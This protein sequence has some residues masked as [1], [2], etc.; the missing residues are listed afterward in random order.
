MMKKL[1]VLSLALIAIGCAKTETTTEETSQTPTTETTT[2]TTT[3]PPAPAATNQSS[4]LLVSKENITLTSNMKQ[5]SSVVELS[6]GCKFDLVVEGFT[7]DTN[8]IKFA[9]YDAATTSTH[10]AGIRFMANPKATKG[11]H[12]AKLAFLNTGGKGDYRDTITVNYTL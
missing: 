11:A 1:L 8:A 4:R 12:S 3:T 6:C 2:T 10:K 5:D 9:T 7:G